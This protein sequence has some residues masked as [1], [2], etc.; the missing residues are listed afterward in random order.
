[1]PYEVPTAFTT[2]LCAS[3]LGALHLTEIES[4]AAIADGTFSG[5]IPFAPSHC[6]EII[7]LDTHIANRTKDLSFSREHPTFTM[8]KIRPNHTPKQEHAVN[9]LA[10]VGLG[11]HSPSR[12]C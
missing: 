6:S 4:W 5:L 11:D 7:F 10:R 2:Q 8:A 3:D 1:M 9:K 12:K